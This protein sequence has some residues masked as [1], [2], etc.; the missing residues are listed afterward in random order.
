MCA[1][2]GD[3]GRAMKARKPTGGMSC[4]VTHDPKVMMAWTRAVLKPTRL[5]LIRVKTKK[6]LSE[7]EWR[8]K[9]ESLKRHSCPFEVCRRWHLFTLQTR[10]YGTATLTQDAAS[11]PCVEH[12]TNTYANTA[13]APL[14]TRHLLFVLNTN[15]PITRSAHVYWGSMDRDRMHKYENMSTI[16]AATRQIPP[17]FWFNRLNSKM[18]IR[19]WLFPFTILTQERFFRVIIFFI[20]LHSSWMVKFSPSFLPGSNRECF[21]LVLKFLRIQ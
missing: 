18:Q 6:K 16:F 9:E 10:G 12:N 15:T 19:H 20:S 8:G 3:E 21:E 1:V 4:D 11:V 13:G 7:R 17:K 2:A 14:P 5:R